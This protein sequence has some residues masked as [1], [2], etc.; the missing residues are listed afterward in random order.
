[1][2]FA[3]T[4]WMICQCDE[5]AGCPGHMDRLNN[6]MQSAHQMP[7]KMPFCFLSAACSAADEILGYSANSGADSLHFH[8]E[9]FWLDGECGIYGIP[10]FPTRLCTECRPQMTMQSMAEG[11]GWYQP[12]NYQGGEKRLHSVLTEKRRAPISDRSVRAFL[13]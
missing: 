2:H 6:V 1:M 7:D 11:I 10:G 8:E 12:D 9:E 4:I 13:N 5:R 3:A